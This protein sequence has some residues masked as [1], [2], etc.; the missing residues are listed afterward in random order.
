MMKATFVLTAAMTLG[1]GLAW[2]QTPAPSSGSHKTATDVT[3][4]DIDTAVAKDYRAVSVSDE[5]RS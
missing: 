5:H 1:S 3:K 2:A 4:A